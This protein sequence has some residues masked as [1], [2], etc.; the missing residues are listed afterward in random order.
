MM[1]INSSMHKR[2]GARSIGDSF[3]AIIRR[4]E[5]GGIYH[6]GE[7]LAFSAQVQVDFIF[8]SPFQ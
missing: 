8:H 5:F 4:L 2:K 3:T 6:V 7:L 1:F